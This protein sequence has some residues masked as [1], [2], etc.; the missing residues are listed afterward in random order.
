VKTRT[1]NTGSFVLLI[2][3]IFV[4]CAVRVSQAVMTLMSSRRLIGQ[5]PTWKHDDACPKLGRS[6]PVNCFCHLIVYAL[7]RASMSR[8]LL[9]GQRGLEKHTSVIG[10]TE[11]GQ[12]R[13]AREQTAMPCGRFSCAMCER[14]FNECVV[15]RGLR[16]VHNV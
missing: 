4:V 8:G 2:S 6:R 3:F 11:V 12:G 10:R 16:A 5:R 14:S 9:I 1:G 7:E 13:S 15:S